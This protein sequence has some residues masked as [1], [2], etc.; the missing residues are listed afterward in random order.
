MGFVA[1]TQYVIYSIGQ[2]AM[3][4]M[5]FTGM[6]EDSRTENSYFIRLGFSAYV[7]F[8][9][10]PD[11]QNPVTRHVLRPAAAATAAMLPTRITR[12]LPRVMAV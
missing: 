7:H 1:R 5:C 9:C 12:L 2:L 8:Q 6:D 3:C 11:S 4:D 10:S